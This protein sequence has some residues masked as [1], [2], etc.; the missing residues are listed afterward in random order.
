M[1]LED[2]LSV[3]ES[4]IYG[5]VFLRI[6][7]QHNHLIHLKTNLTVTGN[8]MNLNLIDKHRSP[9]TEVGVK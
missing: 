2:S 5:I 6:L 7:L 8:F 4:P 3:I 1:I 9:E